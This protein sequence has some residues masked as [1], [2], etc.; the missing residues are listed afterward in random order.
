MLRPIGRGSLPAS[1]VKEELF[2][3][4]LILHNVLQDY[5]PAHRESELESD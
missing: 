2:D 4:E 1:S 5:A 3:F